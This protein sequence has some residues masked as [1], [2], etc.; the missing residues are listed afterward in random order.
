MIHRLKGIERFLKKYPAYHGKIVM[1]IVVIPYSRAFLKLKERKQLIEESIGKIN[2]SYSTLEWQPI[3]YRYTNLTFNELAAIYEV[4][5]VGIVTPLRE[6]LNLMAK[7]YAAAKSEQGVLIVS[8]WLNAT[9]DLTDAVLVNPMDEDELADKIH[10][11]LQMPADIQKNK[12]MALQRK[13][14][15]HAPGQWINDFFSLLFET[16]KQQHDRTR[17]YLTEALAMLLLSEYQE[18]ARRLILLDYDGTLVPFTNDPQEAYP[19]ESLLQLL[20]GW[21]PTIKMTLQ[22]SV[23]ATA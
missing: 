13:V 8:E 6:S 10:E 4:S 9:Y 15:Q 22:L 1:V 7:E 5:D 2:G 12:I 18:A 17:K 21:P 20:Q 3:I 19:D 11:A 23:D 16:K 14:R